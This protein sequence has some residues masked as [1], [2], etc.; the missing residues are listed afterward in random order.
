MT[1][2]KKHFWPDI[3][4]QV[5]ISFLERSLQNDK[6]AQTY[7]FTGPSDLGKFTVALA[8][9][10]NLQ[11]APQ[12][13][14]NSDL[15]ILQPEEEKKSISIEA[16]REF[17]KTLNL[18]SFSNSYKIGIIRKADLLSPAAQSALLKTLEEPREKVVI[19]LLVADQ[20]NLPATVLSRSQ[21]L[22]FHP[23][24]NQI[25][26]DYLISTYQVN[27]SFAKDLASLSL[28]RPLL[29]VKLLQKPEEYQDYLQ[30]AQQALTIPSLNINER[31]V[32]LNQIFKDKT[33]SKQALDSATNVLAMFEGLLRDLLL[34]SWG[35]QDRIQHS[36][37]RPELEEALVVMKERFADDVLLIIL[38]RL[39]LI[40][41]AREY[42]RSNLNPHLVL[43]QIVINF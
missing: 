41:Q 33:W 40:A 31:L 37:L 28:G 12:E 7:I 26:Y 11:G 24:A 3:G 21:I 43:E 8:F 35:N 20:D 19:I 32:V 13:G 4:N 10:R 2:T 18:S 23:V 16:T 17:I 34:L 42:L 22:Y 38:K 14:F 39:K 36:V 6:L 1:K 30:K 5:S 9:A 15:H 27:R 25:I 29:A